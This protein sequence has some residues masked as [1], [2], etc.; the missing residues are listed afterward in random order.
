MINPV[1]NI[2]TIQQPH[3]KGKTQRMLDYVAQMSIMNHLKISAEN[4]R[5]YASIK[6]KIKLIKTGFSYSIKKGSI[7]LPEYKGPLQ[8]NSGKSTSWNSSDDGG[9]WI[10]GDLSKPLNTRGIH[11]CAVLNLVNTTKNNHLLFHI[12]PTS[13]AIDIEE[14]LKKRFSSFDK[15]NI[16]GGDIPETQSTINKIISAVEKL[17]P[18]T[19][20]KFYHSPVSRPEIVAYNGELSYIKDSDFWQTPFKEYK[21]WYISEND[22]S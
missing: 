21:Q 19:M 14:F 7:E 11:D 17:N 22:H 4:F 1:Y 12:Y 18:K 9:G 3:F 13:T 2:Q 20:I 10:K 15:V 16:I 6:D 8:K 5:A